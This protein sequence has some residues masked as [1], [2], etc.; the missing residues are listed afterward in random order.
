[1][2][3]CT[4]W[5]IQYD[6]P[7]QK[8]ERIS[9]DK[10]VVKSDAPVTDKIESE[11]RSPEKKSPDKF[12]DENDVK[13]DDSSG[14]ESSSKAVLPLPLTKSN[15]SP[16]MTFLSIGKPTTACTVT[17]SFSTK[18]ASSLVSARSSRAGQKQ[19]LD[20]FCWKLLHDGMEVLKLNSDK[21]WQTRYLTVSQEVTWLSNEVAGGAK[22]AESSNFPKALLWVKKLTA[23]K[24]Q[25]VNGIEKNGKGGILFS[26]VACVEE[27]TGRHIPVSKKQLH[28]KFKDSVTVVLKSTDEGG[29]KIV[30]FRC[31]TR[32][33]ALVLCAGCNMISKLLHANKQPLL[34]LNNKKLPPSIT[35]TSV[36]DSR[37]KAD[38]FES[39]NVEIE[40]DNDLW[41]V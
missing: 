6:Y 1:L 10:Q 4:I 36:E 24:D 29:S 23:S 38:T 12:S 21:I 7:E 19:L 18:S 13:K 30:Y 37:S 22:E 32:Q 9:F 34:P 11:L 27:L 33:E 40:G 17:P 31:G 15:A 3:H 35:S 8:N 14:E 28:G 41:E 2:I 20:R 16:R 5:F 26:H 25:S 39:R